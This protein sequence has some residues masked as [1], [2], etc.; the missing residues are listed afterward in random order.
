M[1]SSRNV[2]ILIMGKKTAEFLK[3]CYILN[4]FQND[5]LLLI[6]Y[7]S[8]AKLLSS[9]TMHKNIRHMQTI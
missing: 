5:G 9:C 7:T 6:C 4:F 8:F 3:I 1:R 2:H